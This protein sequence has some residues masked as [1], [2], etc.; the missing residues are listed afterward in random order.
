VEPGETLEAAARRELFEE[1]GLLAGEVTALR[2]VLL[3]GESDP[4]WPAFQL[5]VFRC[6]G[7]DGVPLAQDDAAEAGF[8]T[9]DEMA[10]LPLAHFVFEVASEILG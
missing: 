4:S 7:A 2:T 6:G 5:T 8:Y 1:T 10:S 9:L 3:P